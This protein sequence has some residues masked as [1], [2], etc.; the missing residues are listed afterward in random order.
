MH[1]LYY[2]LHKQSDR[3]SNKHKL[4]QLYHIRLLDGKG[5]VSGGYGVRM[6]DK[7]SNKPFNVSHLD[8]AEHNGYDNSNSLMF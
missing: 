1:A 2:L 7:E 8:N 3:M 5:E 6:D 4:H